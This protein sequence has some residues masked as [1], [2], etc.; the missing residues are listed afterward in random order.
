MGI[1]FVSLFCHFIAIIIV[2]M[3]KFTIDIAQDLKLEME[4]YELDWSKV[5]S[6]AI[7]LKIESIKTKYND[8]DQLVDIDINSTSPQA[9][10]ISQPQKNDKKTINLDPNFYF[11]FREVWLDFY[12]WLH[13]TPKPPTSKQ[14]KDLWKL[15]YDP[16]L[17][18]IYSC[19][20]NLLPETTIIYG[21]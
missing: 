6:E 4:R 12:D 10:K 14:I 21:C 19:A 5:C 7:R 20:Y 3:D 15:W 9:I 8:L 16:L 11:T 13:P 17:S 2:V 1:L 18:Y